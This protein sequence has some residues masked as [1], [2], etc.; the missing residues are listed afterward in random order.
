MTGNRRNKINKRTKIYC[1]VALECKLC[2]ICILNILE[3][4]LIFSR[5]ELLLKIFD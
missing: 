3:S 5:K 2:K 4:L 1:P